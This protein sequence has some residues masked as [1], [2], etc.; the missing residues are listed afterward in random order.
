MKLVQKF[1]TK[2]AFRSVQAVFGL[3]IATA[4]PQ[5]AL[6][7]NHGTTFDPPGAGTAAGQGTF[8]QQNLISGA[9]VGYYVDAK[10]VAHGFI[11]SAEGKYTTIDVPK[12]EAVGTQ[13]YG[14]NDEGTVV[15]WW[16]EA[17]GLYHGYLRDDHGDFTYFDVPGA[18]P[19]TIPP[20]S[21]VVVIPLTL[22]I[23]RGGTVTGTYVDEYNVSHCFV[24]SPD[25]L[26]ETF[27]AP[28]AGTG[29]GQGTIGDTNG[30]NR[31]GAIAGGYISDDGV[32]HC[33]VRDPEGA[34]TTFDGPGAGTTPGNGSAA[35]MIDDA[36][37]IPGVSLDDNGLNHAWIRY[38]D[39]TFVT[40]GVT[41]AGTAPGQGT[42]AT[43]ANVAGSTA[44]NYFD[45]NGVG[46]GFVRFRDG[47]I[48]TF[49]VPGQGTGSGQG[50]TASNSINDAGADVGWY[51]DANGAYHG[52]IYESKYHCE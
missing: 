36:G 51:V 17:D 20:G 48:T 10:N 12:P 15:G 26:I 18:A 50:V 49:D 6:A 28:G 45:A 21:K 4:W 23:N 47:R 42:L 40:F 14:I 24:R 46:Y 38:S 19:I 29:S 31:A 16:F 30:I 35:E 39:G 43:A 22:A 13:A 41:R 37:T 2:F 7:Q 1:S 27:D 52:F 44:G 33:L 5:L 8:S 11:R 32:I 34:I 9:I 25:G 3:L